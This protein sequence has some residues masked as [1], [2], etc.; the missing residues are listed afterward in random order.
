MDPKET[1]CLGANCIRLVQDRDNWLALVDVV[2]N[3][4]GSIIRGDFLEWLTNCSVVT[5]DSASVELRSF[6]SCSYREMKRIHGTD[7]F[8]LTAQ[9]HKGGQVYIYT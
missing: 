5:N 8:L 4:L 2:M 1:G 6:V 9:H 7:M 3:Y